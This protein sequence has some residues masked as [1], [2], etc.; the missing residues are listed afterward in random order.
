MKRLL[1]D[2][3]VIGFLTHC[4]GNSILEAILYGTPIIGMPLLAD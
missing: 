2:E 1:L 4:G 3:K